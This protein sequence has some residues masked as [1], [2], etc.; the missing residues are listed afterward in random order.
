[1]VPDLLDTVESVAATDLAALKE[2]VEFLC[3]DL[4]WNIT[5]SA[6]QIFCWSVVDTYC[7]ILTEVH[8][9]EQ[10]TARTAILEELGSIYSSYRAK[11]AISPQNEDPSNFTSVY[12]QNYFDWIKRL[13]QLI[14]KWHA[15]LCTD[16]VT[17]SEVVFCKQRYEEFPK[18]AKILW[19]TEEFGEFVESALNSFAIELDQVSCLLIKFIPEDPNAW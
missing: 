3:D 12:I 15:K 16:E 14:K 5:L 8:I 7:K 1:M 9:Q 13:K 10:M 11:T 18:L 17:Y 6:R 4:N 2:M 19:M